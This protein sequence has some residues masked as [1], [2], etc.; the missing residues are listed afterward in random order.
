MDYSYDT[1]KAPFVIFGALQ[2]LN[3]DYVEKKSVGT[4]KVNP[5]RFGT[6]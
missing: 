5:Y 3:F 2:P 6:T 4:K 1:F